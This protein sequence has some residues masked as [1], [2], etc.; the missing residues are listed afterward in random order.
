M[1]WCPCA[2]GKRR[3]SECR[4]NGGGEN[5]TGGGR[6]S[7]AVYRVADMPVTELGVHEA[8]G[9]GGVG[10]RL[11]GTGSGHRMGEIVV[12]VCGEFVGS[13]I[14]RRSGRVGRIV[15]VLVGRCS[16]VG[17]AVGGGVDT[18]QKALSGIR[19]RVGGVVGGVVGGEY[20]L[21]SYGQHTSWAHQSRTGWFAAAPVSQYVNSASRPQSEPAIAREW[22]QAPPTAARA[23]GA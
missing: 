5:S 11:V 18:I 6:R 21:R 12:G 4:C 17:D 23:I 9:M 3:V 15:G 14:A 7:A 1:R 2:A 19:G 13:E 16:E 20:G 10:D 8:H 22:N